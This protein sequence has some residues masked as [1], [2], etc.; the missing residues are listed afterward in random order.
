MTLTP[1]VLICDT[2]DQVKQVIATA[3]AEKVDG[4]GVLQKP[5][6][7]DIVLTETHEADGKRYALARFELPFDNG[8][9]VMQF[10]IWGVAELTPAALGVAL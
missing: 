6:F 1:G 8:A 7:A 5:M 10:G 9:V 4:C 3:F 2:A